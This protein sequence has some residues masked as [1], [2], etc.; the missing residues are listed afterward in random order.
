MQRYNNYSTWQIIFL[1]VNC[2][3]L[4]LSRLAHLK[5]K[6]H[7]LKLTIQFVHKLGGVNDKALVG[8]LAD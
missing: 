8:A 5:L 3:F 6:T 4:V 7:S 2:K 1:T